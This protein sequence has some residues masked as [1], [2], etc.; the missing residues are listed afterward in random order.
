MG[1]RDGFHKTIWEFR[2]YR[3]HCL[4]VHRWRTQTRQPLPICSASTARS[5]KEGDPK[6]MFTHSLRGKPDTFYWRPAC[7]ATGHGNSTLLRGFAADE[8][9]GSQSGR[10][11][12]ERVPVND[13]RHGAK[14][15]F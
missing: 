11:R 8:L 1:D 6:R 15:E 7:L 13:S 3:A 5:S 4:Q 2:T 12:L 10:W 14:Q 9:C